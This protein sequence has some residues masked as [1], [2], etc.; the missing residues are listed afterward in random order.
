MF[1]S[2]FEKKQGR[3]G[4]HLAILLSLLFLLF[5]QNPGFTRERS[6]SQTVI[7]DELAEAIELIFQEN[8]SQADSV[9]TALIDQFPRHPAGYFMKGVLFWKQGYYMKNY[10]QY[11]KTALKWLGRAVKIAKKNIKENPNDASAYFFGGGAYGYQGSVYARRKSWLKTGY[12]AF[13]GIR[14]LEKAMALDSTLYDI[15]YGSGLYHVLASH[16]PGVVKWIQKLLPIPNGDEKLGIRYLKIAA[17]KGKFTNL[18]A[19]AAL[20]M[21]YVYYDERY[22]D[23]IAL[24]EPLVRRYPRNLDFGTALINAYFYKGL[25]DGSINWDR[26]LALVQHVEN[27][28]RAQN[29]QLD[30]WWSDKLEFITGYSLYMKGQFALAAPLLKDY[31]DKYSKKGASYLTGLGYLTLGKMAD[32]AGNRQ[33]AINFYKKVQKYEAM[34]NEKEL[35]A[36]LLLVP[37]RGE[38]PLVRFV[39]AYAE[40][41]DRP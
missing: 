26:L 31:C 2:W 21:A 18:A 40:L 39:G 30:P 1:G 33:L 20:A 16:Q 11:N 6:R 8:Y 13:R 36:Q 5:L 29:Y 12:A 17:E 9:C 19:L 24:L 34:G 15:Y 25:T 27:Y 7:E 41:P 28:V 10:D 32:I 37:F 38:K 3:F 4:I 22:D 35:A 14:Y 23:A